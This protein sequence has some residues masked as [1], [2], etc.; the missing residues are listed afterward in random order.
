MSDLP[1]A[2]TLSPSDLRDASTMLLPGLARSAAKRE[3]LAD[4]LRLTFDADRGVVAR[5][6]A[7]I[8]RERECCRFLR[9]AMVVPADCAQVQL[10]VTGPPGTGDFMRDLLRAHGRDLLPNER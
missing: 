9:F 7:V 8:D 6:A 4:G 3:L 2:C 1:I 10:E 5:I